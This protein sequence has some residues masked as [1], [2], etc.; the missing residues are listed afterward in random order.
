MASIFK[1]PREKS[2][3][4]ATYWIEF[5][6]EFGKRQRKKGFTDRRLTEQLAAQL[7]DNVRLRTSGLI[8]PIQEKLAAQRKLPIELQLTAFH[9]SL[10]SN[11]EKHVKLTMGR[12]RRIVSGCEFSTLGSIDAE[13][14]RRFVRSLQISESIGHK[15]FNHYLQAFDSFCNWAVTTTRLSSNP[16]SGLVRLNTE[17]DVRHPR[18]ALTP[19]EFCKLLDSARNSSKSIQGYSGEERARIYMFSCFTGLRRAEMAS[20]TLRSFAFDRSP[21]TVTVEAIASKHRRK[22]VLPLHPE[23]VKMLREWTSC[24]KPT[25]NLFPKLDRRKTWL[26]VKKDLERVGIAYQTSDGIAD[27]HASGRHTY[28]TALFRSGASITD[29]R[30]L[31]RHTDVK[32]TMRYTHVG[33]DDQAKALSAMQVPG[34]SNEA[35]QHICRTAGHPTDTDASRR[36]ARWHKEAESRTSNSTEESRSFDTSRQNQAGDGDSCHHPL[37]SGGGGNRTRVPRYLHG[38]FYVCSR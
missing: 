37:Q 22:D 26:M 20:L 7:E 17:V 33:L 30:T 36:D 3:R 23:L 31:A 10:K 4:N 35:S 1:L 38:N 25:D 32:M 16:I 19:D 2:K 14:V 34:T 18:R 28:I 27:F 13:A 11:T 21:P 24:M 5:T 6:N 9:E 8:D 29:A 15:T 12:V